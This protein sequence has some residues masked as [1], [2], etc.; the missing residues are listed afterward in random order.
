MSLSSS[1]KDI[2]YIQEIKR[3]Q[4]NAEYFGLGESDYSAYT[5]A[6]EQ[7][8]SNKRGLAER[9]AG[10]EAEDE[11]YLIALLLGKCEQIT[12]L[13]QKQKISFDKYTI[14]DFLLAVRTSIESSGTQG[15]T[16][17]QRFFVEVKKANEGDVNFI[18][19]KRKYRRLRAYADLYTLPLYFA[20]KIKLANGYYWA[21]LSGKAIE[22]LGSIEEIPYDGR[23]EPCFVTP[24]NELMKEDTAGLWLSNYHIMLEKGFKVIKEYDLQTV[25]AIKTDFGYLQKVRIEYGE[26]SKEVT[27]ASSLTPDVL[28]LTQLARQLAIGSEKTEQISA[29]KVRRKFEAE[30]NYFRFLYSVIPNIVHELHTMNSKTKSRTYTLES[31]SE[32]DIKIAES[33]I[34]LLC[35]LHREGILKLIQMLPNSIYSKR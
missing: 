7:K 33:S 25:T 4:A 19:S 26:K 31:L 13:N 35:E 27:V 12:R 3:V 15:K 16:L 34:A 17:A 23:T 24:W 2:E 28:L 29:T 11:F 1:P 5:K 10:L 20:I 6:L 8:I 30:T 21:L 14:P 32:V 18:I 9:F 22:T